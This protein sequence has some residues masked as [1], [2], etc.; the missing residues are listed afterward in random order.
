VPGGAARA[1]SRPGGKRPAQT[2]IIPPPARAPWFRRLLASPRYLVLVIAGVLIVG[3]AAVFGLS[4]LGTEDSTSPRQTAGGGEEAE[5]AE[6]GERP[7]RR[8][9]VPSQVTVAV[10]NGTTVPGLAAQIG[11][12]IETF[13]FDLGTVTNSTDQ[14]RAESVVLFSDRHQRE[15][16]AV[17]RRLGI[18][19]RERADPESQ[20]LA[21]DATVIVIAGI[22]Q[23]Q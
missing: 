20:G 11:D 14:Q 19:Q 15:A 23:T 16:A 13:G 10:L 17:G 9:I 2:A 4:Q 1:P 8:P 7:R 6:E 22:D 21:G 12:Q 5:P 3:G 18:P